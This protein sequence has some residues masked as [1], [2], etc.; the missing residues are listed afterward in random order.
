MENTKV[1]K[2]TGFISS[3]EFHNDKVKNPL[4]KNYLSKSGLP[5]EL[6]DETIENGWCDEKGNVCFPETFQ[7][8]PV[9]GE[10]G[11]VYLCMN[12]TS[13]KTSLG[14]SMLMKGTYLLFTQ[15]QGVKE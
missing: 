1:V 8:D 13:M 3:G 12:D 2:V 6:I 4:P 14:F 7:P 10:D 9:K 15:P 11:N 5:R